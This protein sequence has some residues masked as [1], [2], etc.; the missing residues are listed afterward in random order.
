M[1]VVTVECN[2]TVN[3]EEFIF[4]TIPDIIDEVSRKP[5]SF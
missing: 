4:T 5:K 3:I 2:D 1:S